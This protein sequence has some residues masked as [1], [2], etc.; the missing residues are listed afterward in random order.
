MSIDG[1]QTRVVNS[2][3]LLLLCRCERVESHRELIFVVHFIGAAKQFMARQ[4]PLCYNTHLRIGVSTSG[5]IL[6]ELKIFMVVHNGHFGY[7]H[8]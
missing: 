8:L 5:G 4:G 1:Q 3:K 7:L 2:H 6:N